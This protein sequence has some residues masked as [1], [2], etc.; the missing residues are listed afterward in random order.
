MNA[1]P[2][3]LLLTVIGA[4]FTAAFLGSLLWLRRQP[5][6]WKS[7]YQLLGLAEIALALALAGFAFSHIQQGTSDGADLLPLG[8]VIGLIEW[9]RRRLRQRTHKDSYRTGT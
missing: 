3:S 6:P 4:A 7:P 9:E 1:S 2:Q 8:L 5:D